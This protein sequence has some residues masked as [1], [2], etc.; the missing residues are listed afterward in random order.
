MK[1]SSVCD[2]RKKHINIDKTTEY[3]QSEL[4]INPIG[5]NLI[6]SLLKKQ[7]I[8]SDNYITLVKQIPLNAQSLMIDMTHIN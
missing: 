7:N 1:T 5:I 4:E 3:L 8:N 6:I 2:I